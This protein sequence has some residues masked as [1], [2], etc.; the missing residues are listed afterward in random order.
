M[1]Y[2]PHNISEIKFYGMDESCASEIKFDLNTDFNGKN[3][4]QNQLLTDFNQQDNSKMIDNS[5]VSIAITGGDM[6]NSLYRIK[7]SYFIIFGGKPDS[8][9]RKYDSENKKWSEYKDM[10]INRYD[11]ST[12]TYKDKKIFIIGGKVAVTYY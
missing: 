12:A 9:T 4:N 11:F 10:N 2:L 5:A 3:P 6:M 1:N 7:N 8:S